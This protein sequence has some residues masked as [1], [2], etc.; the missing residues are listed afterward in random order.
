MHK[1]LTFEEAGRRNLLDKLQWHI[2]HLDISVR[3]ANVLQKLGLTIVSAMA[4]APLAIFYDK[5][6]CGAKTRQEIAEVL[7]ELGLEHEMIFTDLLKRKLGIPLMGDEPHEEEANEV[8]PQKR[9]TLPPKDDL[10][11]RRVRL[12]EELRLLGQ[13]IDIL[14]ATVKIVPASAEILTEEIKKRE[15][16]IVEKNTSYRHLE[17]AIEHYDTLVFMLE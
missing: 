3:L 2:D 15:N 10:I 12:G 11:K 16:Q 5:K 13:E 8:V 1:L 9:P 17:I 7:Q 6:N 14:K 4:Q